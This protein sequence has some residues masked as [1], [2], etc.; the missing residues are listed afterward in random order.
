[1]PHNDKSYD[2]KQSSKGRAKVGSKSAPIP[3]DYKFINYTPTEADKSA[4]RASVP[5]HARWL[6]EIAWATQDGY[7]LS[8]SFKPEGAVFTASLT[9]N[10]PASGNYKCILTGRGTDPTT[11]YLWVAYLHLVRFEG[12]W[13]GSED[14]TWDF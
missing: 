12:A 6:A 14:A 4:I 8:L 2:A 5:E 1:M 11:A 10:D 9:C 13:L 3:S 7:K